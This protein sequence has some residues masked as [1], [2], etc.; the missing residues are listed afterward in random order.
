MFTISTNRFSKSSGTCAG[1]QPTW[2][3]IFS[4]KSPPDITLFYRLL[5][6]NIEDLMPIYTPTVGQAC[7]ECGPIFGTS[8]GIFI[9]ANDKGNV[10][11]V[12]VNW[13]NK[14]IRIIVITDGKRILGLGDLGADGM[15]IPVGKLLLYA[16]CGGVAPSLT[17]PVTV[18][19]EIDA[20]GA[21]L[22][23]SLCLV[24]FG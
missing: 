11:D 18:K 13:P 16:A 12:L 22:F 23:S 19:K 1:K 9:T 5:L 7:L 20:S 17:L 3:D 14:D 21:V 15:G 4:N 8:R 6:E 2:S 10:A 24:F